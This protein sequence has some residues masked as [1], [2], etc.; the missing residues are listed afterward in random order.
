MAEPIKQ[1][2]FREKARETNHEAAPLVAGG[3]R[4]WVQGLPGA[5]GRWVEDHLSRRVDWRWLLPPLHHSLVLLFPLFNLPTNL[6]FKKKK[7]SS[8]FQLTGNLSLRQRRVGETV[9]EP[10]LQSWVFLFPLKK[11]NLKSRK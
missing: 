2:Y 9:A 5:G 1:G 8:Q 4:P 6:F 10:G 11:I 3:R 7:S